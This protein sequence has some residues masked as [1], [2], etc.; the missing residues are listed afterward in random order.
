MD[1]RGDEGKPYGFTLLLNHDSLRTISMIKQQSL[2]LVSNIPMTMLIHA[3]AANTVAIVVAVLMIEVERGVSCNFEVH[4][5]SL[6]QPYL[7][8]ATTDYSCGDVDT[9]IFRFQLRCFLPLSAMEA[10]AGIAGLIAFSA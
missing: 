3:A 6:N 10:V 1:R 7:N 4:A 5:Y 2:V 9:L 8:P